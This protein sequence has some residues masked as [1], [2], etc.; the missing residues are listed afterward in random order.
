MTTKTPGSSDSNRKRND[1]LHVNSMQIHQ[2]VVQNDKIH[3][4]SKSDNK[5]HLTFMLTEKYKII[6]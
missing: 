6:I 1:N 2:K 4:V 3:N 5:P